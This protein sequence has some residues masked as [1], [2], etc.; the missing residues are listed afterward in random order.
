MREYEGNF[1]YDLIQQ[2]I[3][4]NFHVYI[5]KNPNEIK[6]IVIVGA[7][8]GNEIFH[9]LNN[10]PNA[11]IYAFEAY[12]KNFNRLIDNFKN[13]PRVKCF[14]VAISDKEDFINFYELGLE[15]NGSLLNPIQSQTV[16]DIVKVKTMKLESFISEI[17]DLL[18]V[19]VQGAEMQVLKGININ[20]I[21]SLFLEV[22]V[23]NDKV[24]YDNNIFIDE[25]I[26]YLKPTHTLHSI[27]LD[28]PKTSGNAFWNRNNFNKGD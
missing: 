4:K 16:I 11:I 19:D 18:W 6:N 28:I 3:E 24:P 7:F 8:T 5:E 15:G 20:L 17:I 27:G 22:T 13:Q 9:F 10:Y 23:P 21:E 25:L 14:N 1:A 12:I 26:E 2:D